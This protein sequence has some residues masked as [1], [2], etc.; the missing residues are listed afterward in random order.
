MTDNEWTA[1]EGVTPLPDSVE[2]VNDIEPAD[3]DDY[4]DPDFDLDED[5]EMQD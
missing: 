5:P 2:L 3:A 4:E 1:D